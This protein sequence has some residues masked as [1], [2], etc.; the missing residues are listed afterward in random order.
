MYKLIHDARKRLKAHLRD[1][2][3]EAGEVRDI[4][5]DEP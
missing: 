2:G 1:R 3:F 4:F 5:D